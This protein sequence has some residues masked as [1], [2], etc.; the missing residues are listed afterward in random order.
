MSVHAG[1]NRSV[2][3]IKVSDETPPIDRQFISNAA[4]RVQTSTLTPVSPPI[5]P[6][7]LAQSFAQMCYRC[8][9]QVSSTGPNRLEVC[10]YNLSTRMYAS[11]HEIFTHRKCHESNKPAHFFLNFT[12]AFAARTHKYGC[13]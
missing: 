9:Y 2:C 7:P 4:P 6:Q 11:V 13:S 12:R 1:A 3:I 5:F 8:K 10:L